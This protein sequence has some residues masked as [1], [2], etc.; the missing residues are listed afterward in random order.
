MPDFIN[1]QILKNGSA[2]S[3]KKYKGTVYLKK[4]CYSKIECLMSLTGSTSRNDVIEKAVDFYFGYV[5]SQLSQDYLCSVFGTKMEGLVGT[6]GTRISRGNFRSAVE[7]DMLTRM[8]ATV[9]RLSGTDYSKLRRK[10]IDEVK[11][12]NGSIDILKAT[13]EAA[14]TPQTESAE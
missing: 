9:I 13:E 11:R 12:T 5:T 6:L 3:N 1:A 7:M 14:D 10:S 2:D 4:G 8:L